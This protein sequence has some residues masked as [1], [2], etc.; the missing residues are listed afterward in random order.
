MKYQKA[1][2]SKKPPLLA[3]VMLVVYICIFFA[4]AWFSSYQ[5][6]VARE[7]RR[8]FEQRRAQLLD[9]INQLQLEEAE[10]TAIARVHEMAKELQMVPTTEPIQILRDET[11][12]TQ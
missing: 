3:Y 6:Q 11:D 4:S 2:P 12:D 5:N 10:L 8:D 7:M 9:E 1:L